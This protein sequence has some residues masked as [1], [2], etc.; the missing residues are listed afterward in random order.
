[1]SA[2]KAVIEVRHYGPEAVSDPDHSTSV[3]VSYGDMQ[4]HI[5]LETIADVSEL[6]DKLIDVRDRC[7]GH[8][9]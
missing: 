3:F 2:P 4:S 8:G 6:I 5:G 1:M 7:E 9:F